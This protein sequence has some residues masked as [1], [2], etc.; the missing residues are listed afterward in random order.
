[1]L[2]QTSQIRSRHNTRKH[3]YCSA[4]AV[5]CIHLLGTSS[6]TSRCSLWCLC[7]PPALLHA[8]LLLLDGS[9]GTLLVL[10]TG[11]GVFNCFLHQEAT[12]SIAGYLL[13]YVQWEIFM[14]FIIILNLFFCCS[15]PSDYCGNLIWRLPFLFQRCHVSENTSLY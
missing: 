9:R 14:Q 15:V 13:G 4:W 8:G 2:Q 11:A 6:C 5:H 7:W 1:M 12:Y 10:Q 3:V